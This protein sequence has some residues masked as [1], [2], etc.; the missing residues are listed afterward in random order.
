MTGAL[1]AWRRLEGQ[2]RFLL[3]LVGTATFFEGYDRSIVALAL[4]QIRD[5]FEL[6]QSEA[7][8]WLTFLYL[9]ALHALAVRE[10][11]ALARRWLDILGPQYRRLLV[12]VLGTAFLF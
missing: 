11:G 4:R 2:Q 10:A 6:T 1:A 8:F 9:G 7:S 12:L 3:V 5:S